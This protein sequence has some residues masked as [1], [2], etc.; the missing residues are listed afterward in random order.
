MLEKKIR[1]PTSEG[2]NREDVKG[3]RS[4]YISTGVKSQPPSCALV[5]K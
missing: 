1:P 5:R 2:G 4:F 3:C